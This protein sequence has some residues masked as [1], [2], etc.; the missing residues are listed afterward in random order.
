[1]MKGGQM[2]VNWGGGVAPKH[3]LFYLCC[4]GFLGEKRMCGFVGKDE[5]KWQ[6]WERKECNE[7]LLHY[8]FRSKEEH[9]KNQQKKI[10]SVATL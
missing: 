6:I 3:L 5:N 7:P 9:R 2:K 4:F 1:M 8:C 10:W